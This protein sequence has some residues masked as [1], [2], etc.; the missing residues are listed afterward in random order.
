[1][2]TLTITLTYEDVTT[3]DMAEIYNRLSSEVEA[4]VYSDDRVTDIN[5]ETDDE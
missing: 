3:S 1:M 4:L 5:V 2:R